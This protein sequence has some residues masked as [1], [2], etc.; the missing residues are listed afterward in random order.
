MPHV[1]TNV[2]EH[3][4][5]C[6]SRN[7]LMRVRFEVNMNVFAWKED[8]RAIMDSSRAISGTSNVNSVQLRLDTDETRPKCARTLVDVRF[9]V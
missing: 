1:G 4:T 6:N 7:R 3:T 2:L 9:L 8:C 5:L